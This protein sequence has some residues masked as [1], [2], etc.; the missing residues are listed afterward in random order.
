MGISR[1]SE[2]VTLP[3]GRRVAID[4]SVGVVMFCYI[5][6]GDDIYILANK[7]GKKTSE[8]KLKW[9]LPSGYINWDEDGKEAAIRETFEETGLVVP[10]NSV[11]EIEHS[12]SP[13]ENRQNIIFRYIAKIDS[14]ELGREFSSAIPE[15][16]TECKWI[17]IRDIDKYDWAFNQDVT[18]KRI[19]SKL[20]FYE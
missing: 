3:D 16:V 4:R 8:F 15:E 18:I 20:N 10:I 11:R 9:N 19:L 1:E 7:R 17:P 5:F 13:K 6:N 2:L 12:T 14:K